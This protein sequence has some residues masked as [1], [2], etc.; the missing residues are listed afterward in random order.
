MALPLR[1]CF[2]F[3]LQAVSIPTFGPLLRLQ[4]EINGLIVSKDLT[5]S[6]KERMTQN[7][8]EMNIVFSIMVFG[9]N[10]WPLAPPTHDFLMPPELLPTFESFTRYYQTKVRANSGLVVSSLP[11]SSFSLVVP[12]SLPSPPPLPLLC[13]R[14]ILLSFKPL[15][16]SS[17]PSSLTRYP[18]PPSFSSSLPPSSVLPSFSTL[19]P[20]LSLL[21]PPLPPLLPD[22][23]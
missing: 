4:V 13:P 19:A 15:T 18:S 7:H 6:L 2:A 9:T 5:D 21:L 22:T 23:R 20:F 8:D 17:P 11:P 1:L 3:L 10:V 16:F 14:P 12:S